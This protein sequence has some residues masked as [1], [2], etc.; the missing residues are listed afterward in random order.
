MVDEYVFSNYN[1]YLYIPC[2][3]FDNYDL[4]AVW[5]CFKHIKCLSADETDAPEDVE[6]N[7]NN[8]TSVTVTWPS[9]D[10]AK[11]YELVISKDKVVFCTLKFDE[12]GQLVSIDFGNRSASVGFTFTVTGL[13]QESDYKYVFTSLNKSGSVIEKSEGNFTTKCETDVIETLADANISISEGTI[14]CINLDFIIYNVAGQN[15]TAL[16]GSLT[17]GVYVVQIGEDRV[18]VMVP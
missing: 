7:V 4:D 17:P 8:N 15:V 2:E 14:S 11:G 6:V 12:N 10:G 9:V 16:N 13:D 1:S 3:S 18:K 5:G